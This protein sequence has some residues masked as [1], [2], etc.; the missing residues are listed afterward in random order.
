MAFTD[1]WVVTDPPGTE[2]A[3]NIDNEIRK[4]RLQIQERF[5]SKILVD[6][7][8]DPIVVKPEILGNAFKSFVIPGFS[9]QNFVSITSNGVGVNNA[10]VFASLILPPGVLITKVEFFYNSPS[11]VSS[12]GKLQTQF[13]TPGATGITLITSATSAL[14]GDQ[15]IATAPFGHTVVDSE[16]LHLEFAPVFGTVTLFSARVTYSCQD[17][18]FT[19]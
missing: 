16:R 3:K 18:R 17:N 5:N 14:A 11:A 19:L 12:T 8:A 13:L 6:F 15:L 4:L 9:F 2:L 1:P 10:G 7:A